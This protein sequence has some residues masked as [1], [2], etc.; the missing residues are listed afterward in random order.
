[1]PNC[2]GISRAEKNPLAATVINFSNHRRRRNRSKMNYYMLPLFKKHCTAW[3]CCLVVRDEWLF[4]R[5]FGKEVALVVPFIS[6]CLAQHAKK[7]Q[8]VNW[9]ISGS[10]CSAATAVKATQMLP[11]HQ[12]VGPYHWPRDY[13]KGRAIKLP[14]H[15]GE[16]F[17][18]KKSDIVVLR[19]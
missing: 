11:N 10:Q 2:G 15:K 5:T 13:F 14:T 3:C 16:S 6:K 19:Q 1:M 9:A 12:A 18:K 4:L 8:F 7:G 17:S